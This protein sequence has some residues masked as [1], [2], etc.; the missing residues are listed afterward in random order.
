MKKLSS[1]SINGII[2]KCGNLEV[3]LGFAPANILYSYSFADILNEDTGI[4]YQRPKNL[5]HSH[6]FRQ[7]IL[8]PGTSTIPLTFNLRPDLSRYWSLKR[9]KAGNALLT[10][11]PGG[12]VLR[13]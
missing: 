3:F 6:S 13:R 10:L 11:K 1:I 5:T 7:Y 4:G 8:Q 9:E 2:G 12:H